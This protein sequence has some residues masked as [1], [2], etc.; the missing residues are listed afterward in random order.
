MS[1][2]SPTSSSLSTFSLR[3]A[4]LFGGAVLLAGSALGMFYIHKKL[5]FVNSGNYKGKRT[6]VRFHL[7]KIRSSSFGKTSRPKHDCSPAVSANSPI[8][9]GY[10][11]SIHRSEVPV[12]IRI[13]N[14]LQTTQRYGRPYHF[15]YEP[16]F[17][18]LI[19]MR[20]PFSICMMPSPA[21]KR[22]LQSKQ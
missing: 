18:S 11:Q 8:R 13:R 1:A 21:E 19:A 9:C 10:L 4:A 17:S 16:F 5:Q 2:N 22:I 6:R 7:S 14:Y 3:N 12:S 15:R 20:A